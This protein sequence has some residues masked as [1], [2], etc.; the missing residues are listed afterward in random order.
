[1]DIALQ[2]NSVAFFCDVKGN[3]NSQKFIQWWFNDYE[4]IIN[5]ITEQK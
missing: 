5:S 4:T 3:V 1:M 2:S